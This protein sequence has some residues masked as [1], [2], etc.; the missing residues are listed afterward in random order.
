[1]IGRA[2][3][4]LVRWLGRREPGDDSSSDHYSPRH[5]RK[6]VRAIGQA[7]RQQATGRALCP[8]CIHLEARW[9]RDEDPAWPDQVVV[10]VRCSQCQKGLVYPLGP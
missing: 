10:R 2:L 1:M 9:R 7:P 5:R 6:L 4:G 8:F 3:R